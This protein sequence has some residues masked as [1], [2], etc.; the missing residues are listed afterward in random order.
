MGYLPDRKHLISHNCHHRIRR[1]FLSCALILHILS[2]LFN[3]PLHKCHITISYIKVPVNKIQVGAQK[4]TYYDS[5]PLHHHIDNP[6]LQ[7]IPYTILST[8]SI[9]NLQFAETLQIQTLCCVIQYDILNPNLCHTNQCILV[10]V[11][12][13]FIT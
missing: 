2:I 8:A 13:P 6:T 9:C 1:L 7:Y 11:Q 10:Q 4:G 12:D 3:S 5:Q